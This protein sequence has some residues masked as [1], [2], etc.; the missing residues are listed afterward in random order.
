MDMFVE[1]G[2]TGDDVMQK[3]NEVL[4][5]GIVILEARQ[6]DVKSPS[7]STLVDKTRYRI[8]FNESHSDALPERCVQ[9]MAHTEFVIKRKKKGD[10]Q[11]IDL[12]GEVASLTASGSSVSLVAGRGKPIEFA[13]AILADDALLADDIRVEKLEVLFHTH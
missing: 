5:E 4:P 7:L 1:E 6:I 8:T 9:F 10:V 12:R 2:I 3:L 11:L 13:R